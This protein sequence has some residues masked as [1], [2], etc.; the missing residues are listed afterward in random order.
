M[1]SRVCNPGRLLF[2]FGMLWCVVQNVPAAPPTIVPVAPGWAKTTVNTVVFRRNSV[3]THGDN[4]Y[5]AYYDG[6]GYVVLAKRALGSTDWTIRKTRYRG[7]VTDAHN[8]I[9][10]A[11][12]G[13]GTLHMSWN[14]HNDPLRYC[15][16][17]A[18]GSLRLTDTMPMTGSRERRV[19]YPEFYN[20]ADGGLLFLYRDGASGEGDLVMNRYDV[21]TKSWTQLHANLIGGEG[22]R[23]AYWQ[24]AVDTQGIIHVSWVWRETGDVATNHDLCYACSRDGGRTWERSTGDR[25]TMPITV[26]T[27]EYACRIPQGHELINQTSMCADAEGRPYI[28]TFWRPEGTDIPNYQL[29]YHDGR[30]WHTTQVTTRTTPFRLG[31][32]GTKRLPM[33]RPQIVARARDGRSEALVVFRDSERGNRVSVAHC[34]DLA[35]MDWRIID[36]TKES[37]G[38]WEPTLDMALW[39]RDHVL[40]LFVQYNEQREQ[41]K[42]NDTPPQM[43]SILEWKSR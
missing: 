22:E 1:R 13:T 19:T 39:Q 15:R 32:A 21:A 2:V 16:G 11:V 5:V 37:V 23:N 33:S 34:S 38:M 26:D 30:E 24:A 27:A 28:A 20:M 42:R 12:D 43:V 35:A 7:K 18:P 6:K 10:I 25:Y 9:S 36:L 31:G 17:V 3:V 4:Q 8:A 14:H 40:H 29:V 41:N